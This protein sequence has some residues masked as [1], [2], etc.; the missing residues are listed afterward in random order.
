MGAWKTAHWNLAGSAASEEGFF[1]FLKKFWLM[2]ETKI[3]RFRPQPCKQIYSLQN[4]RNP[5]E[6]A[7]KKNWIL[8]A[9]KIGKK[10]KQKGNSLGSLRK[11]AQ[12]DPNKSKNKRFV[13]A[14]YRWVLLCPNMDN[15]NTWTNCNPVFS[16]TD[17][18][19]ISHVLIC[20][21]NSKFTVEYQQT[22]VMSKWESL[23]W[24]F[25][26]WF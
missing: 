2:Y 18:T 26:V 19:P 9:R 7:A 4:T 20:L 8:P 11:N 16:Y 1:P 17:H 6:I 10:F 23:G 5:K 14:N 21:L 22:S 15:T 12:P 13:Q 25:D 3:T 24:Y